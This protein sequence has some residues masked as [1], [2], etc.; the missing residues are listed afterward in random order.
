M[1]V[2][3]LSL[4][5]AERVLATLAGAAPAAGFDFEVLSLGP[6]TGP[7]AVMRP[8]LESAGLRL[9]FLD[10]PRL[11]SPTAVPSL[12]R[13]ISASGADVVHAHLEYAATLS[14]PAARRLGR[15]V[16]C[17]FHHVPHPLRGREAVKERLAVEVAGR[18][19]AVVFVSA[20]SLAGFA[21]RYRRRP[22]WTVIPNGV[23][24]SAFDPA[25]AA[26]PA[27][28]PVPAGAPVAVFV[29]ALRPRKGQDHAI[30]AWPLVLRRAPEA[31][32]V[33]VGSG[34]QE[35]ALREQAA[36]AGV[37]DRVVFAGARVDVATIVRASTLALLPS[38]NEALPT[39]LLEAAACGR[40]AVA[41]AVGGI[42]EAVRDG[43][44]GL[45]VPVGD[46]GAL[47]E[48]VCTLLEDSSRREAMGRAAR[49]LAE[50]RFGA[51]V[52]AANL[53]G[54]YDAVSRDRASAVPAA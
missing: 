31:R 42:P 15:P 32:L 25:P 28:L 7:A 12:R 18:S 27:D 53:R 1:V 29:G 33:L 17:S 34:S 10:I 20:A 39:T 19:S 46:A 54:L 52:W 21:A 4:G 35:P 38:E 26:L 5:G 11:T 22:N 3:S 41:T 51:D 44:T 6:P 47:A 45:L 49:Q 36:A 30:N 2:D 14:L 48:A 43:E 8:L 16:V 23:D 13:A 24:L 9:T 40:P 37:T 50:R